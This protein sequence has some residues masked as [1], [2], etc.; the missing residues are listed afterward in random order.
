VRSHGISDQTI[1][2]AVLG[3]RSLAR[4]LE[5][6]LQRCCAWALLPVQQ[7]DDEDRLAELDEKQQQQRN[8]GDERHRVAAAPET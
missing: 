1:V 5:K 4:G 3:Q 6:Q 8:L 7:H 2:M